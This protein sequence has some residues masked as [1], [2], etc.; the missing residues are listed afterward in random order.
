MRKYS[1]IL[2]IICSALVTRGQ[3]KN[4]QD[5]LRRLLPLQKVE[6]ARMQIKLQIGDYFE[7]TQPDSSLKWYKSIIPENLTDSTSIFNWFNSASDPEKYLFSLGLAKYGALSLK[8]SSSSNAY[9]NVEIALKLAEQINQPQIAVF[10]SDNLAIYYAKSGEK[11]NAILNF[12]KSLT[13]YTQ[14]NNPEGIN[15]SLSNLGALFAQAGNYNK[16]AEYYT[17][18]LKFINQN[19]A[20]LLQTR[21]N[22]AVLYQKSGTHEQSKENWIEALKLSEKLNHEKYSIILS[23]LGSSLYKLGNLNDAINYYSKLNEFSLQNSDN[24]NKLKALNNLAI[25]YTELGNNTKALEYWE[26]TLSMANLFNLTDIV[27]DS[28]LS[29]SN[30]FFNIGNFDSSAIYFEKYISAVKQQSDPKELADA[31]L[32]S[33]KL[34]DKTRRFDKSKE[35]Y[36]E[37]LKIYESINDTAN[38][39]SVN[40]AI[41]KSFTAQGNYSLALEF[42]NAVLVNQSQLPR[43]IVALANQT[44]AEIYRLQLQFAMSLDFYHRA[45]E[46]WLEEK[47]FIKIIECLNTIGSIYEIT[48]NLPMS[49]KFYQLALDISTKNNETESMA[50]VLNNIGVVYRQLGDNAKAKEAYSK[51][52]DI[53]IEKGYSERASYGYNNIGI[54]LEQEGKL[55]SALMYFEKSLEI[56]RKGQDNKGLAASFVNVGNVYKRLNKLAEAEEQFY[57]SLEISQKIGDKQG[58]AFAYGSLAAL[59]LEQNDI[60]T[61]IEFANKNLE[62]AKTIDLK[63]TM[64]E[65]YRQLAWAYEN[66]NQLDLAEED[67][68]RIIDINQQEISSNFSILSENEKEMFFKT[69]SEDY[70]RYYSFALKRK[71]SNNLIT[72]DIYNTI[73]RNKGLLLKSSTAMR[74]AILASNNAEVITK[75]E[76]WTSL[77][78]A[79]A[80]QYSIPSNLRSVQLTEMEKN[81]DNLER[82]LVKNSSEFSDFQGTSTLTWVDIKNKLKDNEVAIEF[83]HFKKSK[84]S[85][86][87]AAL[88][89]S[90]LSEYPIILPLFEEKK[91]EKILGTIGGNNLRFV[92]NVYGTNNEP[93]GQLYNLIWK[94]IEAFIQKNKTVY[95]APSGLLHKVSFA[96]I[97][98]TINHYLIDDFN[99][100][101]VSTTANIGNTSNNETIPMSQVTLFGGITYSV[102][103]EASET[104]KY[105]S[106]TLHETEMISELFRERSINVTRLTDTLAREEEFK[107]LAP[108]S[109]ILHIATHGFFYPDPEKLKQIIDAEKEIG[110][111]QFRGSTDTTRSSNV[112]IQS[113]NPLMRSGLVF[114]KANDFW[115]KTLVSNGEDGVVTALE[116]L[117]IDLRKNQLVVMSACETGLGDIAGSEGVYG[118]QRAF[119]MAGTPKLVMSLWQVPDTETSEFMKTFYTNLIRT[120]NLS[121]SFS[122]TQKAMRQKYDPYFWAAFVLLQ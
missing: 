58:E 2:L 13:F 4:F 108:K 96:A 72:C 46:L 63:K 64:K 113:S 117:N 16:A 40:I 98:K 83:I 102:S 53:S 43:S 77:K 45:Y 121:E 41:S 55:D 91:L 9:E 38:I 115:G 39:A 89:V 59:K 17:E 73:L 86:L 7:K 50:V 114:A 71:N 28:Y 118:L 48:G 67:Y 51:A 32:K 27:K 75:Y 29:L 97:S 54:L 101:L 52:L 104:W 21:I 36:A 6:A 44:L 99:L 81:A 33:G 47:E 100:Q 116:V 5:S 19:P 88:I 85:T 10:C 111:I 57:Q 87:Y 37:A 18:Q 78:Q 12:D 61:S 95:Y 30:I 106:G 112:F 31:Y 80:Q 56:K 110:T 42:V 79:I 23:G 66:T 49:I 35:N 107:S 69:V 24:N 92:Q 15:F 103:Q 25:I 68:K 82:E 14:I 65:A 120:G 105:L 94:P 122:E 26:S 119:R 109:D 22:I 62:I 8:T 74:N 90:N 60:T 20:E 11:N 84:D 76:Q 34:N 70:D 1:I 3:T 93:N